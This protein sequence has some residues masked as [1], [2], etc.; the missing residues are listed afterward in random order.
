MEITMN[1]CT[2]C[3][4]GTYIGNVCSHCHHKK[5]TE[6]ERRSDALPLMSCQNDRYFIGEV[7]GKGGFGITYSAWD[8]VMDR[9]VALKELFPNKSV[10]RG[11][12]GQTVEVQDGDDIYFSAV[13]KKY[14]DEAGLLKLLGGDCGVVQVYD[15]FHYNN[16][17]YYAMEYLEGCD[18][19]AYRMQ[20]GR[21][22]WKFLEPIMN[23]LLNTLGVLHKQNL[24]HRDISPDNIFLTK[25]QKVRLID[26]GSARTYHGIHNFTVHIKAS[27]SPL[28]QL[29]SDGN[30]GPWTDLYALSVTMYLL[31]C[32][33]L[34]PK[35]E[36]RAKGI[37][38]KP[39]TEL[40]PEVP[41]NVAAAIEKGMS[42]K[43]GDRFQSAE[44]YMQALSMTV[45][46]EKPITKFQTQ[47][48]PQPR[49]QP[50]PQMT[51]MVYW[52]YGVSGVYVNH[53]KQLY[54]N[55]KLTFGRRSTCDIAFP[56][57]TV[58]VSRSQCELYLDNAGVLFVRDAGS[59]FGTFLNNMR[60]GS[61]WVR[62]VPGSYLR[63]GNEMFQLT[64]K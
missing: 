22:A 6:S 14:E 16:T 54:R 46:L 1:T 61:N 15:L 59:S 55:Q 53:R 34:P 38:L 31:L 7:L 5:T 63:F 50:Q 47:P 24:I 43:I 20:H 64:C 19:N 36:D 21:L 28:E 27:F 42:V 29:K 12:D 9:R 30:Q 44:E 3:W 58:G 4:Q 26:F 23:E 10:C 11:E 18:L 49:P 40:C 51:G 39:L 41:A 48:G 35:V 37:K 52:M 17:V 56:D 45:D 33:K 25:E 8:H 60:L 62:V 13:K 57:R 32:G 2:A